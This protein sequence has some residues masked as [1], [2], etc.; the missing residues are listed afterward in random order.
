MGRPAERIQS[1]P[2]RRLPTCWFRPRAPRHQKVP[3]V[4][5]I[6]CVLSMCLRVCVLVRG[7]V[8]TLHICRSLET[9]LA[10]WLL[11]DISIAEDLVFCNVQLSSLAVHSFPVSML[12]SSSG[13]ENGRDDD[14]S[15]SS[16]SAILPFQ[17]ASD[18][19]GLQFSFTI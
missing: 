8:S 3:C 5:I 10:P 16:S 4:R 15:S 6:C 18:H 13:D 17:F 9:V 12:F 19:C 1:L 2:N 11:P 14:P 7:S